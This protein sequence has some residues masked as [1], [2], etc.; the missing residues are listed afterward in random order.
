M[1]QAITS[2][3]EKYW[4]L[5]R[6]QKNTENTPLEDISPPPLKVLMSLAALEILPTLHRFDRYQ[7]SILRTATGSNTC[8]GGMDRRC[9]LSLS[10]CSSR[11]GGWL[12]M[13]RGLY[14]LKSTRLFQRNWDGF[15]DIRQNSENRD[16]QTDLKKPT[17]TSVLI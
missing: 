13:R 7:C 14:N 11:C 6:L 4:K 16:G 8:N 3:E 1:T 12:F 5:L 2:E 9:L 15:G 17:T 10:H